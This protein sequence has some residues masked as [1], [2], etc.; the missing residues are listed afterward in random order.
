MDLDSLDVLLVVSSIEKH[1]G[2]KIP[3]E[4]V[5]REVFRNVTTLADFV[6]G[7]GSASAAIAPANGTGDWL[8]KLPHGPEFRFISRV[9]EVVP[10]QSAAGVW[11]VSGTEPFF[12]GHFPGRPVV[13][14]VLLIEALAQI[15]G[16]A[17]AKPGTGGGMLAHAD[18]RFEL[19]ILPPAEIE[20]RATVQTSLG[21][22]S[23][24]EVVVTAAGRVA[25]RGTIALRIG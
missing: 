25:A 15:A 23:M 4:I 22:M 12:A 24:C 19:P 18:V 7:N 5:G 6:R 17:C 20:L 1:F 2:I 8:A 14:G 3:S 9:S 16:L 11:S 10:G 13:P 21:A